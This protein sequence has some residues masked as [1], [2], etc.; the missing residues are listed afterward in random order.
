MKAR[1]VT[2]VGNG[3][4]PVF[5]CVLLGG[6]WT[7]IDTDGDGEVRASLVQKRDGQWVVRENHTAVI[8]PRQEVTVVGYLDE[9]PPERPL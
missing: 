9:P 3:R 6:F 2:L 4:R 7:P 5:Q 8:P 1:I